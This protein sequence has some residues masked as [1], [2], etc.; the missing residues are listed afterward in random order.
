MY[1]YLIH[2]FYDGN[3]F[4]LR[5]RSLSTTIIYLQNIYFLNQTN[6]NSLRRYFSPENIFTKVNDEVVSCPITL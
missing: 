2:I 4:T 1:S 3:F 6:Y 5:L